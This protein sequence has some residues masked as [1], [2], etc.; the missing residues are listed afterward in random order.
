ML[1]KWMKNMFITGMFFKLFH[2][3]NY[4]HSLN[5]HVL[6]QK[7]RAA[8]LCAAMCKQ[9]QVAAKMH[10]A[11]VYIKTCVQRKSQQNLREAMCT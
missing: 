7:L 5:L 3:N 11:C 2:N 6:Q 9:V 10:E 1:E 4:Y 8:K